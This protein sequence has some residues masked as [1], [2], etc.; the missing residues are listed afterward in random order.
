DAIGGGTLGSQILTAM[1]RA[2]NAGTKEFA[3]FGANRFKQLY[4]YGG[5]DRRPTEL[6]RAFGYTWSVSGWLLGPFLDKIGP[7]AT[8]ALKTRIANE[9]TTTFKSHYTAEIS[10]AQALQTDT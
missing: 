9:I 4:V 10:L 3:R 6:S 2:S 5:L 1:E 7:E 8:E